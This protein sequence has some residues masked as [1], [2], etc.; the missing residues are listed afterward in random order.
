M[1]A[2]EAVGMKHLN[3]CELDALQP[4]FRIGQMVAIY[5]DADQG[6]MLGRGRIT[7]HRYRRALGCFDFDI[8]L[9]PTGIKVVAPSYKLRELSPEEIRALWAVRDN[10]NVRQ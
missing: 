8:T 6:L 4:F 3:D 5:S 1:K 10:K 9:H 7:D 2:L